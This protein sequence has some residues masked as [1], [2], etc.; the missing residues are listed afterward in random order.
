MLSDSANNL[1]PPT[2]PHSLGNLSS[3]DIANDDEL[4][5]D[6]SNSSD[7][8]EE[9]K[10]SPQGPCLGSAVCVSITDINM[11]SCVHVESLHSK[12]SVCQMQKKNLNLNDLQNGL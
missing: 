10:W 5:T 6:P 2:A 9:S 12:F 3:L 8:Q 11:R 1:A 4:P 7:T